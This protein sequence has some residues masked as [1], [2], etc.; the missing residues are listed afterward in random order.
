[1][2]SL[3]KSILKYSKCSECDGGVQATP[4][5]TMGIGNPMTPNDSGLLGSGD[6]FDYKGK[7]KRL[8]KQKRRYK[9]AHVDPGLQT[10]DTQLSFA[11]ESILNRPS[12]KKKAEDIVTY[13]DS[14]YYILPLLKQIKAIGDPIK[15]SENID[16]DGFIHSL[17]QYEVDA[18]IYQRRKSRINICSCMIRKSDKIDSWLIDISKNGDDKYRHIC[19][20]FYK[21]RNEIG[22]RIYNF[23]KYG[24]LDQESR[25]RNLFFI[26]PADYFDHL[27]Q[28]TQIDKD[29]YIKG[30]YGKSH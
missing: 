1:M 20:E 23:I 13:S 10:T 18:N 21:I 9:D 22:G 15:I 25:E 26:L 7:K 8:D 24:K 2:L 27:I 6:T 12:L 29:T 16:I 19:G 14:L 4:G 5:N 30:V 3:V 11:N 28:L 17:R